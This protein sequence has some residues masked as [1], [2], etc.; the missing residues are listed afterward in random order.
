MHI[1]LGGIAIVFCIYLGITGYFVPMLIGGFFGSFL[2]VACFGDAIS[3]MIP[4]AIVGALVAAAFKK[5][6]ATSN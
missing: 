5:S 4:G 1:I 6:S 3:G 2:G